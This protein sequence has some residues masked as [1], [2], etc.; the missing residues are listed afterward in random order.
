MPRNLFIVAEIRLYRDGLEQSL[1]SLGFSVAGSAAT[2]A[3][4]LC[5][6]AGQEVDVVLVDMAG[7]DGAAVASEIAE[8]APAAAIVALAVPEQE[9]EVLAC[10]E[11]GVSSYVPREA[12]LADLA[13]AIEA[14]VRGEA[15][16][17]PRIA[18]SLLRRVRDL[19]VRRDE[20]DELPP[21]T[22]RQWEIL[23]LIDEGLSNK[24]IAQRLYIE[25]PTV[26]NHIHNILDKLQVR[27][28]SE[29]AALVR[30]LR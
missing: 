26:K 1:E 23:R 4:A 14:A 10:A 19:S 6:L 22:S 3:E 27:R 8:R 12:S 24:E 30:G 9:S 25:V 28:R 7:I 11:A 13:A 21:L 17:S 5:A 29:A 20:R 16:C 18:A 15:V 2:A